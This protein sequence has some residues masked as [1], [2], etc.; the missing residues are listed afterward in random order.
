MDYY[1]VSFLLII[2]RKMIPKSYSILLGVT[3]TISDVFAQ[4]C[5][6]SV[7][8]TILSFVG[9][10]F[11]WNQFLAR[12]I[13]LHTLLSPNLRLHLY[14]FPGTETW[15]RLAFFQHFKVRRM[16]SEA[17]KFQTVDLFWHVSFITWFHDLF[18]TMWYHRHMSPIWLLHYLNYF[19]KL[20]SL[21]VANVMFLFRWIWM[22]NVY[23]EYML[24]ST[25]PAPQARIT[26]CQTTFG[27]NVCAQ[28]VQVRLK[29]CVRLN[30]SSFVFTLCVRLLVYVAD[31]YVL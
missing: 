16:P 26:S 9:R 15:S 29:T 30:T 13:L 17:K 10:G 20:I 28:A 27:G 23:T 24:I 7:R 25:E 18:W 22:N 2:F 1:V 8:M 12:K 31:K 14:D 5:W 4:A 3:V 21:F 11:T 6:R 19:S